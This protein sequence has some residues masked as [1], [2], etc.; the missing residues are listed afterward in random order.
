MPHES[1]EDKTPE[2]KNQN[3]VNIYLD[4]GDKDRLKR[5]ASYHRTTV[6]RWIREAAIA[7]EKKIA[8]KSEKAT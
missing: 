6:S 2:P 4:P 7:E 3:R 1:D 5:I 8:K